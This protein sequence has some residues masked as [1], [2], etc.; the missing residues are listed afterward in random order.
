METV[1]LPNVE[2]VGSIVLPPESSMSTVT[3]GRIV[4]AVAVSVGCWP[5]A[6]CVG[7]RTTADTTTA[8]LATLEVC[9]AL[10]ATVTV[11]LKVAAL[12]NA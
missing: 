12:G 1:T 5:N 7:T 4:P 2:S 9:P 8:K 11:G 3:A 6:S 10:S